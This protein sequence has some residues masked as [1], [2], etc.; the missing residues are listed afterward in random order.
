M[1]FPYKYEESVTLT[2]SKFRVHNPSRHL[3]AALTAAAEE[4]HETYSMIERELVASANLTTKD[5]L[6]HLIRA[7]APKGNVAPL[8]DYII[9]DTIAGIKSYLAKKEKGDTLAKPPAPRFLAPPTV[10]DIAEAIQNFMGRVSYPITASQ[11][12]KISDLANEGNH[13]KAERMLRVYGNY[14][15]SKAAGAMLRSTL[16]PYPRPITINHSEL[17]RGFILAEKE[18]RFYVLV[19][20]FS[21]GSKYYREG[22]TLPPGFVNMQTGEVLDGIKYPGLILPLETGRRQVRE[23]FSKGVSKSLKIF[24]RGGNVWVNFAFTF[25][26]TPIA[27]QSIL[28]VDRGA[29]IIGAVTI[30]GFDRRVLATDSLCGKA[31]AIEMANHRE[32]IRERQSR[33]IR[34]HRSFSVRGKRS[35]IIIG[36]F[37]NDVVELALK[38][39]SLIVFERLDGSAF[40]LFLTQSQ[41][42]KLQK[43]ITY[44]A[45]VV[46]LPI[47]MEVPPAFT[48]QTC[49]DGHKD[50]RNRLTQDKFKCSVCGHEANADMNASRIIAL[51][52]LHIMETLRAAGKWVK[53][54][55]FE[56]F[57]AWLQNREGEAAAD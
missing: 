27:P 9:A 14:A 16:A 15:V 57:Q 45:T 24:V 46:G 17:N 53:W 49:P 38:Y 42:K 36:E 22:F 5:K 43:M 52:G 18:G 44:K 37:A 51:R 40:N 29:A 35:D 33:G 7:F 26:P 41:I 11:Q 10:S 34:R 31:F 50:S 23:F 2:A 55:K 56:I 13:C 25:E 39:R 12:Q 4:C 19:R 8:R 3:L 48:S 20:L 1:S 28:G 21:A 30:I 54:P 6:D 32:K 47:P